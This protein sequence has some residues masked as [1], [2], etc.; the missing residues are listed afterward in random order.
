MISEVLVPPKERE[1]Q[2]GLTEV[3]KKN[4]RAN[5]KARSDVKKSRGAVRSVDW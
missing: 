4:R 5:K 3:A 2:E 1:M